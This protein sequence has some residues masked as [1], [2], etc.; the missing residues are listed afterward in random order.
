LRADGIPSAETAIPSLSWSEVDA[1][2]GVAILDM[3]AT[4]SRTNYE[5][6][7]TWL[8]TYTVQSVLLM[9]KEEI[10]GKPDMPGGVFLS[11]EF[12][13]DFVADMATSRIFRSTESHTFNWI[14]RENGSRLD[15]PSKESYGE[16]SLVTREH[17]VRFDPNNVISSLDVL[18]DHPDAQNKRIGYVDVKE[19][20]DRQNGQDLLDPRS[21]YGNSFG[22][23]F[24]EYFEGY[25]SEV[26]SPEVTARVFESDG[27]GGKWYRICRPYNDVKYG[28]TFAIFIVSP[29][30]GFNPVRYISAVDID[31]AKPQQERRLAWTKCDEIYV[32]QTAGMFIYE[33]PGSDKVTY[34]RQ[35]ILKQCKLN[36]ELAS[37]QFEYRALG[38]KDGD[39][40]VDNIKK[41]VYMIRDGKAKDLGA[42]GDKYASVEKWTWG[43]KEVAIA[44]MALALLLLVLVCHRRMDAARR[45]A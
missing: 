27:P 43:R 4:Q 22:R 28:K 3:M 13:V 39:V 21:F 5:K 25:K 31:G 2:K 17:Y 38:M 30:S 8:G 45:A 32:P 24:W 6:I 41:V 10:P 1:A 44:S 34:H 7:R 40:L 37:D 15:I 20:A 16:R 29:E 26:S 35:A 23:M 14:S 36:E 12:D 18:P 11:A 19:L 42:F 9:R 33:D